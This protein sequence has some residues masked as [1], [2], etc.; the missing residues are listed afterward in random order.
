MEWAVST[1]AL[2]VAWRELAGTSTHQHDVVI[3]GAA[4]ACWD[5]PALALLCLLNGLQPESE[6]G[7]VEV[8]LDQDGLLHA[9]G[10]I[11]NMSPALAADVVERDLLM[12]LAS[13]ITIRSDASEG[14]LAVRGE[15]HYDSGETVPFS[16]PVGSIHRLEL[17][18]ESTARVTLNCEPGASV[19]SSGKGETVTLGEHVH[20]RGGALGI[21]IDARS[22][23]IPSTIDPQNQAA[24]CVWLA[25]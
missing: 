12:P 21:V 2:R 1:A 10:A 11:G 5:S 15:I 20:L 19:G 8:H 24:E 9:S 6:S 3:G 18:Q 17:D 7:V 25:E 16:V 22:S 4:M 23:L 14:D 13:V